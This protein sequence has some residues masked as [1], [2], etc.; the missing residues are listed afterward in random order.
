MNLRKQDDDKDHS[1][2]IKQEE[3]N[4]CEIQDRVSEIS[5]GAGTGQKELKRIP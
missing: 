2:S 5:E 3:M 4:Q 1:Q